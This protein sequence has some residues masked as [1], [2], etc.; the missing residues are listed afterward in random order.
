MI[1]SDPI[2]KELIEELK[3]TE[4]I[5]DLFKEYN[6]ELEELDYYP[7]YFKD[8]LQV[9]ARTEKGVI[10]INSA[11]KDKPEKIKGYLSHEVTHVLQQTTGDGPTFGSTDDSYLDN[12]YEQE[13]FQNQT[14]YISETSGDEAAE[15]YIEQVLDHHEV[16]SKERTKRKKELLEFANQRVNR[17]E[18]LDLIWKQLK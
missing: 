9:S 14:K 2:F 18:K 15:K 11:L 12:P 5:Q 8:D 17:L 16:P 13:G 10:Y 3:S 1:F 7:I 4:T 6:L